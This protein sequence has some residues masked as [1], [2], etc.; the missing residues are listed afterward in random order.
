MQRA[1]GLIAAAC[2]AA[3]ATAQPEMSAYTIDAGGGTSAGAGVLRLTGT[4]GQP[5]VGELIGS[6]GLALVG[7]FWGL[8]GGPCTADLN[9]DGVVDFNDLLEFLNLYNAGSLLVDFNGD[10]VIDFNDLLEYLN[11]YNEGC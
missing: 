3:A 9:Q 1:I 8:Y 2:C 11:I 7:G 4:V 6:G 5:D 10:G